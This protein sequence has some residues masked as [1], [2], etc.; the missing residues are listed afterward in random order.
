MMKYLIMVNV[1]VLSALNGTA[2]KSA[3]GFTVEGTLDGLEDGTVMYVRTANYIGRRDTLT[4]GKSKGNSFKLAGKVVPEELGREFV[5]SIDIKDAR[6]KKVYTGKD[7][8]IYLDNSNMKVSGKV[9]DKVTISGSQIHEDFVAYNEFLDKKLNVYIN[10]FV[11]PVYKE[12][13]KKLK[14]DTA[15]NAKPIL[16]GASAFMSYMSHKK[17]D[18]SL[19]WMKTHGASLFAPSL[20][21]L[22]YTN[23][24]LQNEEMYAGFSE[25][26][27][28]SYYGIKLKAD[29][30]AQKNVTVG[31]IFPFITLK[32]TEGKQLSLEEIAAENELTVVDF[33]AYWCGPCR[34]NFPHLKDVYSRYKDKGLNVYAISIDTTYK[35]WIDAVKQEKLTWNNVVL[36][37][38]GQENELYGIK[39]V[40]TSFLIDKK[41]KIIAHWVGSMNDLEPIIKQYLK[42]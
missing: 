23:T 30:D 15:A 9:G 35:P 20:T 18:Y 8:T 1:I 17:K 31:S 11:K 22:T 39:A 3:S 40:P 5:L 24:L 25:K 19:E 38:L 12:F 34:A 26:A 36:D 14:A 6:Y 21:L 32:N 10:E 2:Q 29:I 4:S 16:E 41:G 28:H 42:M 37:K 33:W 27:Q 7:M 13:E